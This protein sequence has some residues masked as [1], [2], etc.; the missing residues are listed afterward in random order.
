MPHL[1]H[2]AARLFGTPLMVHERKLRAIVA[3]IGPRFG[4]QPGA[5][6]DDEYYDRPRPERRPYTVTP[7]GIA[8][9]PVVG[10]LAN[11]AGMIDASS[12]PMRGYDGIVSDVSRA[13][14]D[15]EVRGVVLDIESPGGEALGCF[16]A[17]KALSA[18]R[19]GKPIIAAANAYA[20]SAAY[21]IASACDM[22]FVPQ[23]GEVGSIGVVA[24]HVDESGADAKDGLAWSYIFQGAHKVDGNPHEPL[25]DAARTD[26]EGQVAHLYGLFVNGVAESRRMDPE[27]VRATEA[28]CLNAS[29]AITAGIADRIGTLADAIAEAETRSAKTSPTRGRTGARITSLKGSRMNEDD[30]QAAR[31]A[32]AAQEQALAAAR[33]EATQAALAQAAGIM[34]MCQAHGRPQDAAAHIAAGRSR[35]EV[36][37]AL[38]AAKAADQ[39]DRTTSAAHPVGNERKGPA[40]PNATDIYARLNQSAAARKGV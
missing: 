10:L 26:I 35:G 40:G 2:V 36:A 25:T 6:D 19:G 16:D 4:V 24:V 30:M 7:S 21:A 12:S 39:A 27:A 38:L 13:L 5:F 33:T 17:A 9:V 31:E 14:A 29:E 15:N 8:L 1:P 22:I 18:M 11:R 20:Y 23:S 28:R 34:E 32:A 3:G 37:E